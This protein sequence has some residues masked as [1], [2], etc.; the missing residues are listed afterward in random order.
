MKKK[1]S[2]SYLILL[3]SCHA[4]GNPNFDERVEKEV[5]IREEAI[6]FEQEA[7]SR[8]ILDRAREETKR[9]R[10]PEKSSYYIGDPCLFIDLPVCPEKS[11][12]HK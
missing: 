7:E 2:I 1:I 4:A 11:N 5:I 12:E 8:V 9:I 6:R 3:I 10:E